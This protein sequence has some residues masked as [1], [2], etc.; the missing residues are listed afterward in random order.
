MRVAMRFPTRFA[1]SPRSCRPQLVD[2][3]ATLADFVE[4][5]WL[6]L[7]TVVAR[8]SRLGGLGHLHNLDNGWI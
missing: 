8:A 7:R 5:H 2:A 3:F 6:Q 1:C 4:G